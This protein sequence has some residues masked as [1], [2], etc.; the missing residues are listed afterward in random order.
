MGGVGWDRGV[1]GV[2]GEGGAGRGVVTMGLLGFVFFQTFGWLLRL[3]DAFWS[4]HW[5]LWFQSWPLH[6]FRP[7]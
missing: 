1:V 6:I 3:P 7:T 5:F 2:E 4:C